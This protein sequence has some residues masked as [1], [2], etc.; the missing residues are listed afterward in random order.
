MKQEESVYESKWVYT[1]A[2]LMALTPS[3]IKLFCYRSYIGSDDTYIHLQV[4]RNVLAHQGWGLNPGVRCNLSTAPLFTAMLIVAWL[5]CGKLMTGMLQVASCLATTV[6]LLALFVRLRKT[7]GGDLTASFFGLGAAAF[8]CNLWRWNG[9]LMETSY[10]FCA[11]CL[12]LLCFTTFELSPLM[13]ASA[14]LLL[15]LSALLRPELLAVGAVCALLLAWHLRMRKVLSLTALLTGF[16]LPLVAWELFSYSYFGS[17]LP[18]TLRSKTVAGVMLWNPQIIRQYVEL[19]GFSLLWP[20]ILFAGC[21]AV[22]V[23]KRL[24]VPEHLWLPMAG[25]AVIAGFHYLRTSG[26]EAPGRYLLILFPL[27][28]AG[29]AEMLSVA[30]RAMPQW[31]WKSILSTVLLL[32]LG[33][34]LVFNALWIM[35]PLRSF[36]KEY[37]VTMQQAAEY[38]AGATQPQE[39]VLV[40]VDIGVLAYCARGRF[41]IEDG[42]G[43]ASPE[44]VKRR[45]SFHRVRPEL[46]RQQMALV[47]PGFVVES[48]GEAPATLA[49]E[50]PELMPVWSRKYTGHGVTSAS[51]L[52]ANIYRVKPKH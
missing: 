9:T 34:S 12:I 50:I 22:M 20:V 46:V 17:I 29:G 35:P 6:G 24:K 13:A 18:T 19:V 27:V 39:L 32:H 28:C 8:A 5:V 3:L 21:L 44:F 38:L 45:I 14:G 10:A 23:R 4:A 1:A 30:M 49:K 48:Q 31:R 33:M 2:L 47:R 42:A 16:L 7:T 51:Q 52:F 26:L 37:F 41:V 15:G 11:V 40:E 43:L 36:Q 25:T